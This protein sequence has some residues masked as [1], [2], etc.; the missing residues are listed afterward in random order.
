VARPA[1]DR[2]RAFAGFAWNH[3]DPEYY[4]VGLDNWRDKADCA[5][6]DPE[7]FFPERGH[8]REAVRAKAFCGEC[9]V[10]R[11]CLTA[12][13]EMD[14]RFGIWGGVSEATRRPLHSAVNKGADPKDV[15]D[16]YLY[17]QEALRRWAG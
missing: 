16:A 7:T 3:T 2:T 12:A 14:E 13:L 9:E 8:S 11:E 5:E 15:A 4:W 10:R 17:G 6:I 1:T